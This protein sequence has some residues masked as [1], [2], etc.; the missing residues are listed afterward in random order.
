MNRHFIILTVLYF[1]YLSIKA[2]KKEYKIYEDTTYAKLKMV[3]I[4]KSFGFFCWDFNEKLPDGKWY[5]Y[6]IKDKTKKNIEY[7]LCVEGEFKDSLREG[8]FKY[9]DI[10]GEL[11]AIVNYKSGKLNGQCLINDGY[12]M[13]FGLFKRKKVIIHKAYEATFKENKLHGFEIVYIGNDYKGLVYPKWV[14]FYDMGE[15]KGWILYKMKEDNDGNPIITEE[16]KSFGVNE[17]IPENLIDQF[18]YY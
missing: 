9:Y 13:K 12:L 16:V 2:Q 8:T 14:R 17:D 3:T 11:L 15:L 18:W 5:F 4:V 7:Q 6:E 1:F 10:N